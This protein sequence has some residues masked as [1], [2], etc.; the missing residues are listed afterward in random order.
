MK[1]LAIITVLAWA[2]VSAQSAPLNE[3]AQIVGKI[4][5]LPDYNIL[6]EITGGHD[7]FNSTAIQQCFLQSDV[8]DDNNELNWYKNNRELYKSLSIG[9]GLS[10]SF[11]GLF[12]LKFS[13]ESLYKTVSWRDTEIKSASLDYGSYKQVVE[14]NKLCALKSSMLTDSFIADVKSLP[15][16]IADASNEDQWIPYNIFLRKYGSHI[17]TKLYLGARVQ[18]FATTKN[19]TSYKE[20][21]YMARLCLDVA[22]LGNSF[23]VSACANL[24]KEHRKESQTYNMNIATFIRG[25]DPN[26]RAKLQV[27]LDP[28]NIEPFMASAQ[29]SANPIK[30]EF[31][32][33]WELISRL[34]G[35][36][37]DM[38]YRSLNMKGYYG[39]YLEFECPKRKTYDGYVL[40]Q[41]VEVPQ[42]RGHF[43]CEFANEGC[44]SDSDCHIKLGSMCYCYGDTCIKDDKYG[45]PQSLTTQMGHY[46]Q[47]INSYCSYR[48]GVWCGCNKPSRDISTVWDSDTD[49]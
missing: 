15:T 29:Q 10:G 42:D 19:T 13:L 2:S 25:G 36:F 46:G 11:G 28:D 1:V 39:G 41:F 33:V 32:P 49:S 14:L 17:L 4:F 34:D 31:T 43:Q 38:Y 21:D 44:R 8:H 40:Q 5:Y 12:T 35:P 23:N 20:S 9:A 30:Y 3:N 24:S 18:Q 27:S 16:K 45:R 37:S 26:F 48:V 7:I 47:G 6:N 22:G